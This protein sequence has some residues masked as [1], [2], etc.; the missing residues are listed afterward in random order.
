[1][2]VGWL[3]SYFRGVGK[4]VSLFWGP[5]CLSPGNRGST[6]LCSNIANVGK[7]MFSRKVEKSK[8]K[9]G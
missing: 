3:S 9:K 7:I 1:M 2:R 4:C 6:H 5:F 8:N